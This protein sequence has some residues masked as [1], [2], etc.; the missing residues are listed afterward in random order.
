MKNAFTLLFLAVLGLSVSSVSAQSSSAEP[1]GL[2]VRFSPAPKQPEPEASPQPTTAPE[3][4]ALEQPAPEA[5]AAETA[6]VAEPTPAAAVEAA[7]AAAPAERVV[8]TG[9]VYG[10]DKK[11]LLGATVLLKGTST[12]TSTN[13]FGYYSLEVPPG[14][15]SIQFDRLGYAGREV[16]ASNFLPVTVELQPT[17]KKPKR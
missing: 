5:P 7:P 17:G 2:A 4:P 1:Q 14:M 16:K 6:V 3:T 12:I 10:E 15:N 9:Y 8:L 13:S 11:P